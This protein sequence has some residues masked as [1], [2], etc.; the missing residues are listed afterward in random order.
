M[1][2]L[3]VWSRCN[4]SGVREKA[5]LRL[6]RLPDLAF[7]LQVEALEGASRRGLSSPFGT[8]GTSV[9]RVRE[10]CNNEEAFISLVPSFCSDGELVATLA[11]AALV[12]AFLARFVAA[13]AA[14]TAE[15]DWI[16]LIVSGCC[17]LWNDVE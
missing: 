10:S 6:L 12:G 15:A 17:C 11:E 2:D 9:L 7:V 8:S 16:R 13:E 1:A 5:T 4:I 14:L 3:E